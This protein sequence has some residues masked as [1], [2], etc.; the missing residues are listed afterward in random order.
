MGDDKGEI[1]N[2]LHHIQDNLKLSITL[3]LFLYL[4]GAFV[5]HYIEQWSFL[6]SIY[7]MTATFTTVGYGD[8]IPKTDIGKLFTIVIA[9]TG[10]SVGFYLIYSI[11]A[12][13]E[14]KIDQ[15][16]IKFAHK[17]YKGFI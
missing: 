1:H 9:W 2:G 14:R 15:R 16:I 4:I 13:R 6:D 17:R 12:Y 7:F 10:I 5:Y 3:L 11:S 8:I